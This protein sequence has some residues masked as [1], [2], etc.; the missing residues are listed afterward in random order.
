MVKTKVRYSFNYDPALHSDLVEAKDDV[1]FED[2]NGNLYVQFKKGQLIPEKVYE[3]VFGESFPRKHDEKSLEVMDFKFEAK[4]QP[5]KE[6]QTEKEELKDE[7]ESN[8]EKVEDKKEE[9]KISKKK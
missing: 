5:K 3:Y 8:E 9:K 1:F 6:V 4:N 2:K 7:L